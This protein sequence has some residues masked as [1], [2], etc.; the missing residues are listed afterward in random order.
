[1]SQEK[2]V[3]GV[4]YRISLPSE[5][6]GQ[7]RTL[8]EQL[9]VRFP[10]LYRLLADRL[11]GLPPGSRIRRLML[12]RIGRRAAAAANRRDFDVLL[13]GFDPT[14]KFELPESLVGG[15]VP[16]DLLG[17]HRGHD[18]YFRMWRGLSEAWPDLKIEPRNSSTSATGCS[19]LAVSRRTGGIAGSRSINLSFSSSPC[20][21]VGDAAEGLR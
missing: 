5:R 11:M 21:G 12:A 16:P 9:F 3:R 14:I 4:R 6:A 17:V 10:A 7:R 15:F 8:D 18:G 1:M 13:Y 2:I 20:G 19:P